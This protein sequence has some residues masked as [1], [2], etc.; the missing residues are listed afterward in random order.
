MV[1]GADTAPLHV[2]NGD[3]VVST[4]ERAQLPGRGDGRLFARI[5][6]WSRQAC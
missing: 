2:T 4:L 3:S 1:A 6:G 5:T